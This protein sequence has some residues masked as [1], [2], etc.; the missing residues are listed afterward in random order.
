ML[1]PIRDHISKFLSDRLAGEALQ[2]VVREFKDQSIKPPGNDQVIA[3][4]YL[5]TVDLIKHNPSFADFLIKLIRKRLDLTASH[6]VNL[7]FRALQYIKLFTNNPASKTI[8]LKTLRTYL[9]KSHLKSGWLRDLKKLLSDQKTKD[10][11]TE[12][13][14]TKDTSTTKYQRYVSLYAL[15]NWFFPK[16]SVTVADFGCGGNY[17]LKGLELNEKFD[18]VEDHTSRKLFTALLKERI[19]LKWGLGVDKEDPDSQSS[20]NWRLACSFYPK[21]LNKINSVLQFEKRISESKKIDFFKANLI[22]A[23]IKKVL[24]FDIVIISTL[25]YQISSRKNQ[26]LIVNKAKN[27]LKRNGILIVQDFIVVDKNRNLDF[28]QSWFNRPYSYKTLIASSETNWRFL[29]IFRW[30]NGRCLKVK[31]GQDL[32]LLLNNYLPTNTSRAALAHSTS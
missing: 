25:L 30:E 8:N 32:K 16:Q 12:L 31:D 7:Y 19:R 5:A 6:F 21:E 14:L 18:K 4:C 13:L 28:T 27:C 3:A 9:D 15:T 10:E 17:G 26:Q 1:F 20:H 22:T 29:E 11:L 23:K 24:K 2:K